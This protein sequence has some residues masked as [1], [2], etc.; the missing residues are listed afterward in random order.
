M[1]ND[2]KHWTKKVGV[3]FKLMRPIARDGL[4]TAY[5]HE[6]NWSKA[7]NILSSAFTQEAMR[8]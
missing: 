5:N 8:R 2:E 3:L 7:H 4:F 1:I 6:P